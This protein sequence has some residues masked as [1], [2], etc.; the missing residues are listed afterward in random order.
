VENDMSDLVRAI[1]DLH[2]SKGFGRGVVKLNSE[3]AFAHSEAL[4]E[5]SKK[6]RKSR[7]EISPKKSQSS[8]LAEKKSDFI[9]LVYPFAGDRNEI[10]AAANGLNEA[11]GITLSDSGPTSSDEVDADTS[12]NPKSAASGQVSRLINDSKK[13]DTTQGKVRQRAHYV[14]VRVEDYERLEPMEWLN[15]SLVDFWMQW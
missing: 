4:V 5:D 12:V 1:Q 11:S 15:D 3:E 2:T 8:F 9:L 6:E 10:E 14:T 7:F 13:P